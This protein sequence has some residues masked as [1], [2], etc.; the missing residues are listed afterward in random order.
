MPAGSSQLGVGD[1]VYEN[2]VPRLA[3]QRK[4]LDSVDLPFQATLEPQNFRP[5]REQELTFSMY[6][7]G[8]TEVYSIDLPTGKLTNY[9]NAPEIYDEPE[10]IFP[11][12]QHTLVESDHHMPEAT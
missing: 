12:G 7:Y 9:S 3:N 8:S 6:D 5:G 1:I 11:D 4:V 10:G 2:G